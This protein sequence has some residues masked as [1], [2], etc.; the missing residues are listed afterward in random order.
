MREDNVYFGHERRRYPRLKSHIA[1]IYKVNEPLT[2]HMHLGD[3][4]ITATALDLCE[5]GIAIS[6]NHNIP[7]NTFLLIKFTIFKIDSDNR[8]TLYG[9][10]VINGEVRYNTLLEDNIRRIGICF[11]KI[12]EGDKIEVANFVKMMRR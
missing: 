10:M 8:S 7:L 3:K 12:E 4:E 9:P 11:T 2:V 5:S 6:T 1:I